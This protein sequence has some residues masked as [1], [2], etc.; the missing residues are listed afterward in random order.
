MRI[1]LSSIYV[2]E[3]QRKD[4][5]KKEMEELQADLKDNGQITPI[6]LRPPGTEDLTEEGYD[7]QPWVLV[8]GGR[9]VFAAGMLGW[10]DI[11]GYVREE[12]AILTA[13][14]L[15]LHENLIRKPMTYEEEVAAK[16][17]I[18]ELRK[19]ENPEITQRELAKELGTNVATL[20]RDIETHR[21]L[22]K[23]PS[24]KGAGTKHAVLNAG[25]MLEESEHRVRHMQEQAA[26]KASEPSLVGL[27]EERI[28][29]DTALEFVRRL[30]QNSV[31]LFLCD[32]PYAYNYWKLGGKA[33]TSEG[34]H[35][36]SYD[37]DPERNAAMYRVLFPEMVRAAR[38]TGWLVLFCGY[39]TYQ[40]FEELATEC[41]AAHAS[42]RHPQFP[43]QCEIA[44]KN[45]T[46]DPC[47]FLKPEPHPW[48]WYRPNSRNQ[49][50]Y[51]QR[52][53]K[54]FAELIFVCNMGKARIVRTPFPSV[55]VHDT[56][57]GA[58]RIHANQ[59]PIPLYR[60]LIEGLTFAGD[61]VVDLFFG[62]GTSLAAAASL[63]R[64]PM[65][66]DSNPS[67]LGFALGAVRKWQQ[68]ITK[69]QIE[70]SFR[71]YQQ[72]LQM[73]VPEDDAG[74]VDEP[75]PGQEPTT[76]SRSSAGRTEG[77][78]YDWEVFK[79][80]ATWLGYIK[81]DSHNMAQIRHNTE[82][83][84]VEELMDLCDYLDSL[85]SLGILDACCCTPEEAQQAVSE[86]R[87]KKDE[88]E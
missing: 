66:C 49:P 11:E 80:G 21:L 5:G 42:Y 83:A 78:S 77:Q 7:K 38:E 67:M 56:E 20:S 34:D 64:V 50:R 81:Y 37:D 14:I 39:E 13:Q 18:F 88:P 61:T 72:G 87:V 35:L 51:A 75:P 19:K 28:K 55:L 25:K 69:D 46:V 17:A 44:A 45:P 79:V 85:N 82:E 23:Y 53:A 9:R 59:K 86:W 76:K 41:C 48:I 24:L 47:R 15:E 40:L 52:H 68:P 62:S 73:E 27:A 8:A 71:R 36:S 3:R 58:E 12:M 74:E 43:R 63:A 60:Q 31:D 4:Y 70:A 22:T 26:D 10:E 33:D 1:P 29:T 16:A 65:G 57:Y 30:P 2:G 84:L 6:T 54:N 32:G